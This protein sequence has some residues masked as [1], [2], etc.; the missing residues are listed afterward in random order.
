LVT[1]ETSLLNPFQFPNSKTWLT[2]TAAAGKA[3]ARLDG[4]ARASMWLSFGPSQLL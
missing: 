4:G 3:T 2:V 1:A